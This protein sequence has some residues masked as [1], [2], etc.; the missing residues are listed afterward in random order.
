M[1]LAADTTLP[2]GTVLVKPLV[3]PGQCCCEWLQQV[4]VHSSH[5]AA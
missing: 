2:D 4:S 3:P 1:A 5:A